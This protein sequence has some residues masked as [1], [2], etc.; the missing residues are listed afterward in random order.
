MDKIRRGAAS[1]VA[2]KVSKGNLHM[3]LAKKSK[4]EIT[5]I[6]AKMAQSM[7][8]LVPE[9]VLN[10]ALITK[11]QSGGKIRYKTKIIRKKKKTKKRKHTKKRQHTKKR[12]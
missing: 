10:E 5:G 7:T 11:I 1:V 4:D 12:R 6:R 2:G 8:A 9:A 3:A